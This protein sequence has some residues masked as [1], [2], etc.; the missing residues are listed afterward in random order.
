MDSMVQLC[1]VSFTYRHRSTPSVKDVSLHISAGEFLLLTGAT[2]CGKST[3]L[4][5]LNG[6]IPHESGG[7]LAGK[8]L[9]GGRSTSDLGVAEMSRTVGMVFQNPDDQ[10]FSTT[11]FDEVAFV[12]ENMG[13]TS[14]QIEPQ[15]WEALQL[16]GLLDK[17]EA[18][19]H[20]LSGG[21][22]Q[23]LAVAA[24]LAAK[25]KV[26]ALDEPISQL[27]PQG[28]VELLSVLRQ[29]NAN[30]GITIIIVEHRL[31]EVLPLCHKVAIMDAGKLIW[32]GKCEEAYGRPELFA[33]YG[34]RL[35][36]PVTICH[37]LGV[38]VSSAKVSE[39]VTAIRQ[40]YA[41]PHYEVLAAAT[42][43]ARPE[44]LPTKLPAVVTARSL[45]FYYDNPAQLILKEVDFTLFPGQFI[46]LMGSNGAGKST[47]LHL[48]GGLLKPAAGEITVLGQ[49]SAVS[50][51]VGMVLQ[52]PDFMLFNSTVREEI[53]FSLQQQ[54]Q[55]DAAGWTGYCQ[56]LVDKLGLS[57]LEEEFP[58][59]LSRGQRLRVAIAAVL[60]CRPP[61]LLLDEPTT[62]QDIGH[63]E[64]I[65]LLL[66]EYTRQ[67]GSIVF[68]SHDTEVAARFADRIVVMHQGQIVA[69]GAPAAIFQDQ[70]ILKTS[71]LKPPA[72]L[73]TAQALYHGTALTVEEV[74][75]YVRQTCLGSFSGEN[76]AS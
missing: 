26:L 4:K 72:V 45:S 50:P 47:L 11:V 32:Q 17:A 71:G 5:M 28:A 38:A 31:H 67:D 73:L 16:V 29:L 42:A 51:A 49:E 13:M 23:R 39:A 57:G 21:Q 70:V 69:D 18:S 33:A 34:L 35:P 44:A 58:L 54:R 75:G 52:N 2:G 19:V 66:K 68:C 27:D 43:P 64:D 6:L 56:L 62:G 1:N 9:V 46:A 59:A 10:I 48:I 7:T 12:L 25:P 15:V 61:V 14:V 41:V 40:R 22:K 20:S 63:I 76:P 24:V 8:V 65:A 53:G 37:Q 36:Q 60:S 55:G 74:V 30:L 3:L